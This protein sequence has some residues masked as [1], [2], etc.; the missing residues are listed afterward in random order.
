MRDLCCVQTGLHVAAQVV[1]CGDLCA[2]RVFGIVGC[3]LMLCYRSVPISGLQSAG[4]V[5]VA[6]DDLLAMM[7]WVWPPESRIKTQP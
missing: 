3:A 1:V 6:F 7:L 2:K 4:L 5:S